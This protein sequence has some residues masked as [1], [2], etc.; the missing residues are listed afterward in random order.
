MKKVLTLAVLMLPMALWF[1]LTIINI[2]IELLCEHTIQLADRIETK[3][4]KK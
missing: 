1:V 2:V 4:I 3:I